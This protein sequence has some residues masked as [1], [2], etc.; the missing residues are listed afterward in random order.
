MGK[1]KKMGVRDVGHVGEITS[2]GIAP[3]ERREVG[4]RNKIRMETVV[5]KILEKE[6]IRGRVSPKED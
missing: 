5:A 4:V 1:E 6:E 3:K 2:K